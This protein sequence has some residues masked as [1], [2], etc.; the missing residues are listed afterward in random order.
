MWKLLTFLYTSIF[1]ITSEKSSYFPVHYVL[2]KN[3]H[4]RTYIHTMLLIKFVSK[5]NS[6]HRI[7]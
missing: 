4:I 1:I 5:K 7:K 2:K 3:V 6:T